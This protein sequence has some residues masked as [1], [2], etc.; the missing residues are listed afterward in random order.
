VLGRFGCQKT[1]GKDFHG[2]RE[3]PANNRETVTH[4]SLYLRG[5]IGVILLPLSRL[6]VNSLPT[7]WTYDGF[8]RTTLEVR[9]DGN[10]TSTSYDYCSG[11]NGGSAACP[12][13]GAYR[14]TSTPQNSSGAQNGPQVVVHAD[15]LGRT[16]ANDIQGPGGRVIRTATQFNTYGLPA[17]T[18]RPYY[19]DNGTPR[20]SVMAYDVLGRVTQANDVGWEPMAL[21][22]TG[23]MGIPLLGANIAPKT[24]KD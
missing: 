6:D 2:N 23:C 14:I 15:A 16:F 5:N 9:A 1:T 11:V 18:S 13:N 12:T 8:G 21:K 7:T 4:L 24:E 10:R 22:E 3:A 20:W 17:Q 19:T